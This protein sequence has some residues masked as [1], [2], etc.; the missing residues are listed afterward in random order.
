MTA[1]DTSIPERGIETALLIEQRDEP[2]GNDAW[3]IAI[4]FAGITNPDDGIAG[5]GN[6]S[7]SIDGNTGYMQ[8][9]MR[10]KAGLAA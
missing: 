5:H 3:S 9:R 7:R 6:V 8:R 1:G 10:T 2:R 4:S